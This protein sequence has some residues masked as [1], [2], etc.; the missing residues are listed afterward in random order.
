MSGGPE[1]RVMKRLAAIMGS[2]C[3]LVMMASPALAA[4]A[5]GGAGLW[6]RGLI[7]L[8]AGLGL[9]LAAFGAAL[10]QGRATAAAMEAIGR[11][12][13]AADRNFPPLVVG[14]EL[15]QALALY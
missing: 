11:H 1:G 9:G 10:G 14:L 15:M 12:A 5:E 2:G 13:H 7:A 3:W 6:Y 8:A 4:E